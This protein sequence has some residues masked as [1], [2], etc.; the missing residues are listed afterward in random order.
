MLFGYSLVMVEEVCTQFSS[1]IMQHSVDEVSNK[2]RSWWANEGRRNSTVLEWRRR[3]P[4]VEEATG[5][6]RRNSTVEA[7]KVGANKRNSTI[8]GRDGNCLGSSSYDFAFRGL[9][10]FLLKSSATM[11]RPNH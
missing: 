6:W 9:L 5:A 7:N 10:L 1:D 11:E 4:T 3:N 8:E 2:G